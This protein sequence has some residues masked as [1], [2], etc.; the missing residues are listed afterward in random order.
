MCVCVSLERVPSSVDSEYSRCDCI[1]ERCILSWNMELKETQ[2][3]VI[4]SGFIDY[5]FVLESSEDMPCTLIY[6]CITVMSPTSSGVTPTMTTGD[7]ITTD[8]PGPPGGLST[9]AIIGIAVSI[10]AIFIAIIV[11]IILLFILFGRC[12]FSLGTLHVFASA[13]YKQ[14]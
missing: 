14:C 1:P 9:G 6:F 13:A 12:E 3:S 4:L 8:P 11:A 5:L 10:L 7:V 2:K